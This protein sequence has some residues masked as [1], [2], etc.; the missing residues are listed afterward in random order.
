LA[1]AKRLGAPEKR[2]QEP[3]KGNPMPGKRTLASAKNNPSP[4]F[5]T[6]PPSFSA[7]RG[8]AH[9]SAKSQRAYLIWLRKKTKTI[10]PLKKEKNPNLWLLNIMLIHYGQKLSS[11]N[12]HKLRLYKAS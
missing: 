4:I 12:P 2:I 5:G 9:R 3:T 7:L 11:S 1:P 6:L 8:A 10:P